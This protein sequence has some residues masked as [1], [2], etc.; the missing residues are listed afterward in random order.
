MHLYLTGYSLLTPLETPSR[1]TFRAILHGQSL[2][3]RGIIP[4]SLLR[5]AAPDPAT[6]LLSNPLIDKSIR[7]AL[8][9]ALRATHAA[10]WSPKIIADPN[11]ALFAATSK[12]PI[13]S[14]L[15]AADHLGST[16]QIPPDLA[17]QIALGPAVMAHHLARALQIT[18]PLHTSVAACSSG[19]HALHRAARALAHGECDRAL[20]LAA[21]ASV[22]ALF[23][24]SF[25]RLGVLA[26]P[27]ADGHRRCRPFDPAGAGFFITEAAAAITLETHPTPNSLQLEQTWIGADATHLLAID[28]ATRAL[29]TGLRR[30]LTHSVDFIHAHAT[31]TTHDA[32]ELAAL[33]SLTAYNSP[34][35]FSHKRWLGHSLG[36]AGLASLVLSAQCHHAHLTLESQPLPTPARSLT[37]SQGFGGHIGVAVLK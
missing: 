2:T 9:A 3:D 24:S 23:E 30:A 19:M 33:R 8:V 29:R 15:A 37:L 31:G 5:P 36:A 32:H 6:N 4:E 10:H 18:G 35:I 17:E 21:D 11:T 25:A 34:P 22:H 14:W 16:G 28:P 26:P 20:V 27:D 13:L 1:S 12:G 7:M